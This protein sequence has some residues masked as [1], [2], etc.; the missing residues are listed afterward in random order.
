MARKPV[1]AC[2]HGQGDAECVVVI[3]DDG[4]SWIYNFDDYEWSEMAPIPGTKAAEKLE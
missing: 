3:C 4:S 2:T 1:A